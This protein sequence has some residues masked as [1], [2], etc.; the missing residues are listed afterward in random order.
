MVLTMPPTPP[1]ST[2]T[3]TTRALKHLVA[4]GDQDSRSSTAARQGGADASGG[5]SPLW[6]VLFL[7]IAACLSYG[8]FF[9]KGK[10]VDVLLENAGLVLRSCQ[11]R[12]NR[13][14]AG[15]LQRIYAPGRIQNP[16]CPHGHGENPDSEVGLPRTASEARAQRSLVMTDGGSRE[17]TLDREST[18]EQFRG[19]WAAHLRR[20]GQ[21]EFP[22]CP[23]EPTGPR[24]GTL[25]A[26]P[27][28]G[29]T[30]RQARLE[31]SRSR[32]S[33]RSPGEKPQGGPFAGGG[34]PPGSPTATSPVAAS[35][36]NVFNMVFCT[37]CRRSGYPL[38]MSGQGL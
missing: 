18:S 7:V 6:T 8:F 10:G 38:L 31:S 22:E 5:L 24:A 27:S 16:A 13:G 32:D 25:L 4:L 21:P 9:S 30:V 12:R 1:P 36:L 2:T 17:G 29:E 15:S 37:G 14:P 26:N 23:S 28:G 11:G 3:T 19:P 34:T 33:E 20:P 35:S